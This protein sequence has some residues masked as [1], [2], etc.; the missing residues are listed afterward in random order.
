MFVGLVIIFDFTGVNS[1]FANATSTNK[2]GKTPIV[3]L[4]NGN[5]NYGQT[6]KKTSSIIGTVSSI[7]G[8]KITI[9]GKT[10]FGT[11][12]TASVF[13]VDVTSAKILR[14]NATSTISSIT[15]GDLILVQGTTNG[16]N[17]VAT[18]VRDDF[19][20][21]LGIANGNKNGQK[22]NTNQIQGNKQPVVMGTV[23]MINGSTII[24]TNNNNVQYTIDVTNA[25]IL[26]NNATTT[27]LGIAK[28]DSVFVQGTINGTSS[29][30]ASM[31]FVAQNKLANQAENQPIKQEQNKSIFT[32]IGNFFSHLFGSKK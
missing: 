15:K 1:V 22:N 9:S 10:G 31:V 6:K 4:H 21:G 20:P 25:K 29:I 14:N 28:G 8:N 3:Q 13:T 18:I 2:T 11:S 27:I 24:I 16:T 12:T 26:K 30:T 17:I 5:I 23:S 19:R 7:S 32:T